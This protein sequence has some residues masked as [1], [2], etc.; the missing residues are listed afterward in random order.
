M[1]SKNTISF[2]I[3]KETRSELDNYW[4]KVRES[5][6][7]DDDDFQQKKTRRKDWLDWYSKSKAEKERY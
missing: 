6:V 5:N 3:T 1:P 2:R 4:K 7:S